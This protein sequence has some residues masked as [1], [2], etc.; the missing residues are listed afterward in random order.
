ML[1]TNMEM[2]HALWRLA[3][4]RRAGL[5]CPSPAQWRGGLSAAACWSRDTRPGGEARPHAAPQVRVRGEGGGGG[6][7]I[8]RILGR[9]AVFMR[10]PTFLSVAPATHLPVSRFCYP[11]SCQS[12]L[13]AAPPLAIPPDV[14]RCRASSQLAA[15]G[16]ML[17]GSQDTSDCRLHI[18]AVTRHCCHQPWPLPWAADS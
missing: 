2:P 4:M 16:M 10:L 5:C 12:P 9:A 7:S 17:E 8:C 15:L 18:V 13:P 11:P 6:R 1:N 3:T 14:C